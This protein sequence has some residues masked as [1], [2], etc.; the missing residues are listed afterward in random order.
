MTTFMLE[1]IDWSTR[2]IKVDFMRIWEMSQQKQYSIVIHSLNPRQRSV[3]VC[4]DMTSHPTKL[5]AKEMDSVTAAFKSCESGLR[6][7]TIKEEVDSIGYYVAFTRFSAE[8][9]EG[10]ADG[11]AEPLGPR[12]CGHPQ[13]ARQVPRRDED[14]VQI[15]VTIRRKGLLYYPDFC[16]V[17]LER[18]RESKE[19]EEDFYQYTFKV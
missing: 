4:H 19:E 5:T 17:V 9:S 7:A 12:V 14:C 16:D 1:E 10:D 6:G 3:S 18:F 2:E 8:C 11:G 13:W 15:M